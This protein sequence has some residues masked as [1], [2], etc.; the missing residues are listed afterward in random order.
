MKRLAALV[1]ALGLLTAACNGHDGHSDTAGGNDDQAERTVEV[2]MVD[3]AFRPERLD[4][5]RGETVRFVFLN[6]GDATHDAF[7]GGPPAQQ[8]HEREMRA[9][10]AGGAVGHS[11]DMESGLTVTPGGRGELTYTFDDVGP[12]EI[13]CHQPGHYAAGMKL[14]VSV[15]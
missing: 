8:D 14:P 2:E 10:D 4:I 12:I 9:M 3:I 11:G 13:G 7:I 6:N 5:E 15:V 1:V